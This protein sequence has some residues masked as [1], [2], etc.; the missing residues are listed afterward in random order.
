[1]IVSLSAVDDSSSK[2]EEAEKEVKKEGEAE[3]NGKEP[4][5]ASNE[6]TARLNKNSEPSCLKTR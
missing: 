5:K 1:M 6:V 4:A 3:K 2:N